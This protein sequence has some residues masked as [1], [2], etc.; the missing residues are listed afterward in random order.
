MNNRIITYISKTLQIEE[1]QVKNT[2]QLHEEGATI[3]FIARYRKES[4][5][6][7]TDLEIIELLK[8]Y[9]QQTELEKRKE[10]I[11]KS[12]EEQGISDSDLLENIQAADN[13]SK[14]EDLYL[15]Y[16]P[17]RK[18]RASIAKER[19]LEPLAKMLMSEKPFDVELTAKKFID[20]K[21]E[22]QN[23]EDA[24]QGARDIIAE[25]ISEMGW[26]RD[27]LRQ[28]FQRNAQF[29]SK[30]IKGKEEE[31][32]NYET[33]FDWEELAHKAPSHRILAMF[34]AEKEGFIRLKVIPSQEDAIEILE[35]KI[36]RSDSQAG[37]Q[38][39]LALKDSV[40]RLLFPSLETE[41]R[42]QLQQKAEEASVKVFSE[43]LRQLLL[44]PPMGQVNVLAI[45]PGFRSGCKVVC[46][47]KHGKLLHNETIYPHPPQNEAVPAI[48]KLKSLVNS[49]Q[50]EAISVGNGT[51]GRET[52]TLLKKIKFDR[53]VIAV[54]VNEDGASVYSASEAGRKEF[55]QY[56]V[57][58]RGAVSIGRRLQD[59]LAE[60]VK[61]DPK[62]MG[63][64]QYQ[65]DINANLLKENLKTTVELCVNAVGVSLNTASEELLTYV[66]GIG[67]AL[68]K[69]IIEQRDSN[70]KF[71]SRKDLKKIKGLGD[72]AFQQAAGFLRIEDGKEPLDAS[73]IHPEHYDIVTKMADKL[74]TDVFQLIGNREVKKLIHI[75]D[76]VSNEVGLPSLKDILDELEKP[77]RDPRK[78]FEIFHLDNTIHKIEDLH[79]GMVLPAVVTNI[80][81]FGAFVNLGIKENGLIHKSQIAD[82]FVNNPADYLRINQQ[83]KVKVLEV[84]LVRKRISL[85]L[86]SVN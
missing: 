47:D 84:D 55:P 72:K 16:R 51:A 34:R 52:E 53:E 59:P 31:G 11:L 18:T 69:R 50:I 58:V 17:K 63:V 23:A 33:Y 39:L 22:I 14:L 71:E 26:V 80:T 75:E 1:W 66:S 78:K 20:P 28:K 5:G 19:G 38:K 21:Q 45:D 4:S 77:G 76:F 70:G 15:P 7:L 46:L 35:R 73:A 79:P 44:S 30:I 12:L 6:G 3:P 25:W 13:I 85:T 61:I 82:E 2:L 62:S 9:E 42:Q 27:L 74:N 8:V 68:A 57:T 49:Y 48:K 29:S 37:E 64:G 67:P 81:D 86:R 56:D 40:K 24:L 10:A 54:M 32:A 60:I 83:L 43:N 36:V 41:L 65:H